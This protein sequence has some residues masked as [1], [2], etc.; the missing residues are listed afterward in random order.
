MIKERRLIFF[1]LSF[2]DIMACG[3]GAV[4]LLFLILRHN[5]VVEVQPDPRLAA[6][7]EML[8][9][10]VRDAEVERSDLLNS[11]EELELQLVTTQGL[12]QRYLTELNE[13]EESIQSD[14]EGASRAPPAVEELNA[15]RQDGGGRV[16]RPDPPVPRRGN[17]QYLTGLTLAE[18]G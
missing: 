1:S 14:P 8:K 4:I 16:R 5:V 15:R 7:V 9:E 6:E 10:D 12:S 13:V 11:I 2:L 17:R 3:F 18:S